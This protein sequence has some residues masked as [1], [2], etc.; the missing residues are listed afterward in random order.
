MQKKNKTT[1]KRCPV[2]A[3]L[4]KCHKRKHAGKKG[5]LWSAKLS[6]STEKKSLR[7]ESRT[8]RPEKQYWR[9]SS[10]AA[11]EITL[12]EAVTQAIGIFVKQVVFLTVNHHGPLPLRDVHSTIEENNV[13]RPWGILSLFTACLQLWVKSPCFLLRLMSYTL[14]SIQRRK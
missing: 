11:S 14:K 2:K 6:R 3:C 10:I 4:I 5:A 12:P 9:E 13:E 1:T 7:E 8:K